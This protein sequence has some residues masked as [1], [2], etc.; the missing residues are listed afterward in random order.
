MDEEIA[1]RK[2]TLSGGPGKDIE[3]IRAVTSQRTLDLV[4]S[5]QQTVIDELVSRALKAADEEPVQSIIVSGGVAAN[6][7]LRQRFASIHY[8]FYFPTLALSTDNAAMI[9]AAG[10]P[11]LLRG[12][13]SDFSVKAQPSLA[14]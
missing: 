7:G 8:P 11:R 14:L 10:Y 2:R 5:F 13:R 1:E 12:E 4:A 3:A 6:A 9:A